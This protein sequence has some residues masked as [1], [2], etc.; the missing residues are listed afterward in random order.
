MADS[1]VAFIGVGSSAIERRSDRSIVSFAVDAAVAAIADAGLTRDDI[2]GYVG[3]PKAP[4]AAALH[5]EGADEVPVRLMT[6]R[7]GL[8]NLSFAIDLSNAFV[9]EMAA[10]ASYALRC[11]ACKYVLGVRALYNFPDVR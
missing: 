7:L 5:V 9:T 11:G 10:T 4:N 6:E 8:N 3:S 2:D 1:K